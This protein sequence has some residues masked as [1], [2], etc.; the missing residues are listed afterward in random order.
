MSGSC[1]VSLD[2]QGFTLTHVLLLKEQLRCLTHYR[3]L[4]VQSSQFPGCLQGFSSNQHFQSPSCG[5][6]HF[7]KILLAFSAAQGMPTTHEEAGHSPRQLCEWEPA[8]IDENEL[9][10]LTE[11]NGWIYYLELQKLINNS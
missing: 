10:S 9:T 11:L 2:D 8:V 6:H 3:S 1:E 7:R 4:S 5:I